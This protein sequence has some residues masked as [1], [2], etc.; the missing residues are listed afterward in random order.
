MLTSQT[1]ANVSLVIEALYAVASQPERWDQVVDALDGAPAEAAPEDEQAAG[2]VRLAAEHSDG[3]GF[4]GAGVI[5]IGPGGGAV[6]ANPAGEAVFQQRLGL[7]EAQGLKFFNPANHEALTQ[8]RSRLRSGSAQVIVKF[9]QTHDEAPHFAY[10]IPAAALP[11]GMAGDLPQ[12]ALMGTGATAVLFPAVETTD[13]LWAS[14]RESFGL[15]PAETRLAARLKDGLTLKEAAS[16]L[17]LSLH[18]VRN[19][20]RAV[21]EKM[22]LNRQSELVRALTQLGALAG[23]FQPTSPAIAATER[24]ARTA[25]PDIAFHLLPDGRRLAWRG[26]GAPAGRPVLLAHQGLGCSILPRGSDDLARDLGLWLICPERPGAG[27]SDPHPAF[28]L[29][30]VGADMADLVRSLGVG[31]VQIAAFMSGAPFG[32]ATAAHLGPQVDRILLASTRPSGQMA[33]TAAD[34]AHR[35]VLFRR[36]ILRNAW[37][38]EALFAVFRL[39]LNHRTLE[40]FVRAA[41]SAPSDGAY[42][43]GNPEVLDFIGDYISESL[44]VTSRG[45]ADEIRCAARAP[46]LNLTGLAAPITVWHGQDDPMVTAEQ[47]SAWLGGNQPQT[48]RVFPDTGHFLPHRHWPEVLGW[49]AEG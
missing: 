12:A 17:E 41:A 42:L 43:D 44:A 22:G 23:S 45:I 19:Q 36:R 38:A 26:Y 33:E 16:E 8:A 46:R 48:L 47:V 1:K 27:R 30:A 34:A 29:E 4:A 40:R 28:S 5:L 3:Q 25:S 6:A 32:L 9:A 37:L 2:L 13:R 49:L 39:R 18:T 14:V 15:T 20:L 24:G 10:V 11:A 35:V 31:Q 21:F 7:I